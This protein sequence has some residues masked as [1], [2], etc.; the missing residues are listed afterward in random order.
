MIN[1]KRKRCS[2]F[3][4]QR[5]G[6]IS[7]IKNVALRFPPPLKTE[8]QFLISSTEITTTSAKGNCRR[9]LNRLHIYDIVIENNKTIFSKGSQNRSRCVLHRSER[10][11]N[12]D[13]NQG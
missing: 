8:P 1:R 2:T 5:T 10:K 12:F 9:S 11:A 7:K 3:F 6:E 4:T 13:R